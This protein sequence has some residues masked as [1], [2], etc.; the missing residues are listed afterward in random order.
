MDDGKPRPSRAYIL[1]GETD[2]KE[3]NTREADGNKCHGERESKARDAGR[4]GVVLAAMR[5]VR[6]GLLR[7]RW[8]EDLRK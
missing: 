4:V 7:W 1:R 6:E 2:N 5:V 3:G 8:S